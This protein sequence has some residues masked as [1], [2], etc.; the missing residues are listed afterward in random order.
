M[1][2]DRYDCIECGFE[3]VEGRPHA[4]LQLGCGTPGKSPCCDA[5]LRGLGDMFECLECSKLYGVE[6][7]RMQRFGEDAARVVR[8][9]A[10]PWDLPAVGALI[11]RTARAWRVI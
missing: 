7:I 3:R 1:N 5:K 2:G 9:A 6:T 11:V 10:E 4:C 8:A